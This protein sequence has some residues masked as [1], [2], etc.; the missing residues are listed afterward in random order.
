MAPVGSLGNWRVPGVPRC[1]TQC[2]DKH[3]TSVA[4]RERQFALSCHPRLVGLCSHSSPLH[5]PK[6]SP[7]GDEHPLPNTAAAVQVT[8]RPSNCRPAVSWLA[9]VS[10]A[11]QTIIL[12]LHADRCQSIDR[13]PVQRRGFDGN[14]AL[15]L[16]CDRQPTAAVV[17][18]RQHGGPEASESKALP[19]YRNFCASSFAAG[20]LIA[21]ATPL[22]GWPQG[23]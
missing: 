9:D 7:S 19:A 11:R 14:S 17:E 6:P 22:P 23:P 2:A 3:L 15:D 18:R 10:F 1:K 20:V 13:R 16:Q 12:S 21:F 5:L 4:R 8:W